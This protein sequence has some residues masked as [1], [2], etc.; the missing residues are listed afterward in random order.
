MANIYRHAG[1][2][3][4]AVS[5]LAFTS[6]YHLS[7]KRLAVFISGFICHQSRALC[8]SGQLLLEVSM[9][10]YKQWSGVQFLLLPLNAAQVS[11]D[12]S[13]ATAAGLFKS[14]SNRPPM[15]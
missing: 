14:K 10:R 12:I 11:P 13:S 1:N 7:Y 3:C 4:V 2:I 6:F 5:L 8:S 9:S 15:K